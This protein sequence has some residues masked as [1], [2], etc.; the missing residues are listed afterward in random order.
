MKCSGNFSL[1]LWQVK[2][3]GRILWERGNLC[4]HEGANAPGTS[5]QSC[6]RS[7]GCGYAA[8]RPM[9]QSRQ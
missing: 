1:N 2:Q 3:P 5:G 6:P 4:P 9:R 8:L 7:F